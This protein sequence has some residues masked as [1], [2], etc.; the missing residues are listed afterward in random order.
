MRAP[1]W[2]GFAF[3]VGR[4]STFNHRAPDAVTGVQISD[5]R[6]FQRS[7]LLGPMAPVG[8]TKDDGVVHRSVCFTAI[9]YRYTSPTEFYRGLG[10]PEP[11][12]FMPGTKAAGS[13]IGAS[14]KVGPCF[15]CHLPLE[16]PGWQVYSKRSNAI[17]KNRTHVLGVRLFTSNSDC[18]RRVSDEADEPTAYS[19]R[20]QT[21]GKITSW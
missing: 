20:T 8:M 5:R 11:M 15:M 17:M 7:C 4:L 3:P 16:L 2:H 9:D 1:T 6:V 13:R 10:S 18:G 19:A 14:G 12:P 21:T